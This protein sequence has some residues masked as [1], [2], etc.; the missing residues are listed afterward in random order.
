[1]P[2]PPADARA[3]C[4]AGVPNLS[5]TMYPFGNSTNE[6]VPLKI[7]ISKYF[8]MTNHKYI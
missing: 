2:I 6:H 1:M 5:L 4:L 3:Y 8:I 7:L